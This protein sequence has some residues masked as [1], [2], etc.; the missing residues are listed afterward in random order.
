V[1]SRAA[2]HPAA[3]TGRETELKL[4]ARPED[5]ATLA[6][7]PVLAAAREGAA[8]EQHQLTTYYDT[9]DL[10]LARAGVALRV[11]EF[12]R[13]RW[14]Q[15]LKTLCGTASGDAVAVAVRREWEWPLA[16]PTPD[17]ALLAGAEIGRLL[18]AEAAAAL[19][20]IFATDV[21]RTTLVIRPDSLTAI[22]VALDRGVLRA[23]EAE[24][25]I[26]E[27]ELELLAG[28]VGPL[29]DLA[30]ALHQAVPLRIATES[31][32]DAGFHLVTGE[33]AR[34]RQPAPLALAATTTVA[35]AFRHAVRHAL[36]ALLDNEAAA[37][38]ALEDEPGAELSALHTL[39]AALRRLRNA[40]ALFEP[41]LA[42][43][44]TAALA[45]ECRDLAA[46][47]GPA[48]RWTRVAALAPTTPAT[49]P[50][51]AAAQRAANQLARATILGAGF[52]RLVLTFGAWIEQERW[53]ADADEAH[54]A[55]LARPMSDLAGPWLEHLHRRVR[56]ADPQSRESGA[57]ADEGLKRLRRRLRRFHDALDILRGLYAPAET[58]VLLAAVEA[59]RT[60]LDALNDLALTRTL[61]GSVAGS[62]ADA[63]LPQQIAA[64]QQALADSLRAFRAAAPFWK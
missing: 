2:Y 35:E 49:A 31:K 50:A 42:S 61:L 26:C 12:D 8:L 15:G 41:A 3:S 64:R 48:H 56:K 37:L 23:G 29:F 34:P 44:A 62:E 5:L 24:R 6:G 4:H 33:P 54:R 16:G 10:A 38:A 25:P 20:P 18:P 27:V 60:E 22:E 52:T 40:L 17:A 30:L 57:V 39:R 11:R 53:A 59:L 21:R 58:R 1:P 7:H 45:A 32:A 43:G 36:G 28:P 47:L 46:G 9:P 13:R 63:G 14:I 19:T 55:L 51:L